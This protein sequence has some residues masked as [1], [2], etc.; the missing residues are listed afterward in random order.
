MIA[1]KLREFRSA[2][3][4]ADYLLI[5]AIIIAMNAV[6]VWWVNEDT[7]P[8]NWDEGAHLSRSLFYR[9]HLLNL[10]AVTFLVT[11]AVYPP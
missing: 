7:R 8:P 2:P 4:C 10:D 5:A 9:E 6:T 11:Y 3:N 1:A